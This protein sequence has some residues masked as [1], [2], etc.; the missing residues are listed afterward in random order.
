[1]LSH[2]G[3]ELTLVTVARTGD[4][5]SGRFQVTE[6]RPSEAVWHD[7]VVVEPA[8]SRSEKLTVAPLT[9]VPVVFRTIFTRAMAS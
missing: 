4:R 1:M 2:V 8:L 3:F 7:L 9:A 5:L 6:H